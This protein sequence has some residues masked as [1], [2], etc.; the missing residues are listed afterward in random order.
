[1]HEKLL[2]LVNRFK[3]IEGIRVDHIDGL[4]DPATYLKRLNKTVPLI[5]IEKILARNEDLPSGWPISGTTGYEFIDHI[6]RIFTQ[7]DYYKIIKNYWYKNIEP[8]WNNF[9]ICVLHGKCIVLDLLFPSELKRLVHLSEQSGISEKKTKQFWSA[10]IKT[11]P[12]YRTYI[13]DTVSA[14]DRELIKKLL[15]EV[16]RFSVHGFDRT[17]EKI[18][19][20]LL[21]PSSDIQRKIVHEWQQ[22]SGPVMAKGLEDTA[23]YLYT[24]VTAFNEVGAEPDSPLETPANF[25]N[26]LNHKTQRYPLN[27][28]ATST[29]DTKRSEDTRHRLYALCDR[30]EEWIAFYR[31]SSKIAAPYKI[32]NVPDLAEEYFLYQAIL[33]IWPLNDTINDDWKGRIQA[34]MRKALREAKTHTNWLE[35]DTDYEKKVENFVNALLNDRRFLNLAMNFSKYLSW[36]GALTSLSVLTLK[37]MSSGI[38]DFYQGSEVWNFSLVDPDNRR[39]ICFSDHFIL[40][41]KYNALNQ[42]LQPDDFFNSMQQ[43]WRDGAIKLWLTKI[44]LNIRHE[45]FGVENLL[46]MTCLQLSGKR[47]EN[48]MAYRI[49]SHDKTLIITFPRHCGLLFSSEYNALHVPPG[50]W[51][52]T[53]IEQKITGFNLITKQPVNNSDLLADLLNKFPVAVIRV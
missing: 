7:P 26:W 11:L 34:Y 21:N 27:F 53:K 50:Y 32:G 22:L 2:T 8:Q 45:Y 20:L 51:E 40:L 5:W 30:P 49:V 43:N 28:K 41:E 4:I 31:N 13:V 17:K 24:P 52:N 33:G 3:I 25:V 36:A 10:L 23:H 18:S 38:P 39:P 44:L 9:K 37:I 19:A 35:S 14:E 42:T 12:V 47:A 29:H 48:A 1:M 15:D 46:R 16:C 6:N